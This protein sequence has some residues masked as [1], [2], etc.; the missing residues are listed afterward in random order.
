M[1][2]FVRAADISSGVAL[3]ILFV[4]NEKKSES[5]LQ[6]GFREVIQATAYL[7]LLR[8]VNPPGLHPPSLPADDALSPEDR[9][10]I[11]RVN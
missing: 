3:V 1:I 2:K 6:S 8:F 9:L 10:T 4:L 11:D 5:R 7:N